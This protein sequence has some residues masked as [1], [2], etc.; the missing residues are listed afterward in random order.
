M[1]K[2]GSTISMED[3]W[4]WIIAI[5]LVLAM[6]GAGVTMHASRLCTRLLR[7]VVAASTDG[8]QLH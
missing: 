5:A 3:L 6:A 1:L 2:I 4:W 7:W 8:V